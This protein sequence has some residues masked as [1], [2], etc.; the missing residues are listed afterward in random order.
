MRNGSRDEKAP[1][2]PASPTAP[3][4]AGVTVAP[5]ATE[6]TATPSA[7]EVAPSAAAAA[8]VRL[9]TG[10]FVKPDDGRRYRVTTTDAGDITLNF[11]SR[12][13]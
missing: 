6:M 7:A 5:A 11:P 9:G 4:T 2:V 10:E 12:A 3:A 8:V 13:R 1:S